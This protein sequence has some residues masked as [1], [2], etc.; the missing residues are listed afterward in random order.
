MPSQESIWH[1]AHYLSN[2]ST[3]WLKS[4]K[5]N[6]TNP[7]VFRVIQS[8][9][10][11]WSFVSRDRRTVLVPKSFTWGFRGVRD[12]HQEPIPIP[13]IPCHGLGEFKMTEKNN[14][15]LSHKLFKFSWQFAIK[16]QIY[17]IHSDSEECRTITWGLHFSKNM[18]AVRRGKKSVSLGGYKRK[19]H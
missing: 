12:G 13:A 10:W 4:I 15:T 1:T 9:G 14:N 7:V 8:I 17:S 19:W 16:H 18:S 11:P 3:T 2:E 5:D 6:F